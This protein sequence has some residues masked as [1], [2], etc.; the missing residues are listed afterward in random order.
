MK[1][2]IK[3]KGYYDFSVILEDE[4]E[5]QEISGITDYEQA[6]YMRQEMIDSYN[7]FKDEEA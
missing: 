1:V 3:R 6:K 5:I 4:F 7:Y 2:T